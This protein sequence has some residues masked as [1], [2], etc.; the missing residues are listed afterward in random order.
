MA[1]KTHQQKSPRLLRGFQWDLAR[2]MECLDFLLE[3]IPKYADW[4]Y[5]QVYLNLED[6]FDYPSVSDVGRKGAFRTQEMEKLTATAGLRGIK[7][8]PIVPLMGHAAYLM[9][10]PELSRLAERKNASGNPLQC[11]Q[12]CPLHEDT[13][14][15]A[16]K[17]LSDVRPYCTAGLVHVGLDESF[18]IGTCPRCR[19]DVAHI[20]LARHFANHV[21]RLHAVCQKLGLRMGLW[22]DMLYYVPDAIPLLPKDI[23]VYDWYYY[24]FRRLPK[25]ELFNFA[26][27]DLTGR[28]VDAGIAVFGCPNNGPFSKEPI[29]PFLD[30]LRN[31]ISWWDYCHAK[32][33]HGILITSWSSARTSPELNMLVDAAAASLWLNSGERDPQ[34]LLEHGIYRMWGT[35]KPMAVKLVGSVEKYQY[36]GYYRWQTYDNWGALANGDSVAPFR[37]EEKYFRKLVHQAEDVETSIA[38]RNSLLIRH[39]IA[40]KDLFLTEGSGQI[41]RARRFMSRMCPTL[42]L[43]CLDQIQEAG[44]SLRA[45]SRNALKATRTVWLRSRTKAETNPME[46][47]IRAD[48]RKLTEFEH[49]VKRVRKDPAHIFRSNPMT[50]QWQ[51]LFWVRN[52]EPALQGAIVQVRENN[53]GWKDVHSVWSLEFLAESGQETANFRR[54]HSVALD[55][56]GTHPLELRLAVRGFGRL[57]ISD[58][59]LTNGVQTMTPQKILNTD[60]PVTN[61]KGLLRS[62]PPH[63]VLGIRTPK[64]GFPPMDWSANQSGVEVEFLP[65][66]KI[67]NSL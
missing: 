33:A 12:I 14:D 50:G 9:K 38:F 5:D 48:Q 1:V 7:V 4:G 28:L 36:T 15:V 41:F 39:Y 21:L 10:V 31:V 6:A 32:H 13:L 18:D 62:A 45:A 53:G 54:H 42:A 8:I 37:R 66:R 16:E 58:L 20:G 44:H 27:V 26:E 34:K 65:T 47:M 23:V 59:C 46:Q 29:T 2:Q 24:P 17:L 3:A 57:E 61:L 51:L 55:W 60:G 30:R 40:Q 25:V 22:G 11:G 67:L 64:S 63:A 49:F 52:F 19:K 56:D 43:G 35:R